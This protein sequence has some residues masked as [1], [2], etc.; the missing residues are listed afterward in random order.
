MH[1]KDARRLRSL[2]YFLAGAL[3]GSVITAE[4]MIDLVA[5]AYGSPREEVITQIEW[6]I[7]PVTPTR[8]TDGDVE[9]RP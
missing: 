3:A 1:S 8:A 7:Q 4:K 2:G 9:E 5:A 6:Y